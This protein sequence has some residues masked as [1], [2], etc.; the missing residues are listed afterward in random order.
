MKFT[1]HETKFHGN[2]SNVIPR[3]DLEQ[4]VANALGRASVVALLGP[5]Q[6]G[7]TTLARQFLSPDHPNY[8]DLEDP[9]SVARLSE[10]MTALESLEG[11]VVLDEIQHQPELFRILRVFVD[12]IESKT[13]FLVLGSAAP[14]L[15]HQATESLAGRIAYIQLSGFNLGEVGAD[16]LSR[17]WLRG[18]MPRSYLAA[19]ETDWFSWHTDF[20]RSYIERDLPQAGVTLAPPTILRFWT[21]LAHLHGQVFNGSDIARSI[22]ISE[23]TVRRWLDLFANLYLIHLLQPWHANV[24]KR[25]VKAP[26]LYLNDSGMLHALLGLRS[27]PALE[28]HPRCGASFEGLALREAIRVADADEVYFWGTHNRAELDL[29]LIRNGKRYGVEIKRADAPTVTPSM[30]IALSDLEL[31]RITVLYSGATSYPLSDKI[32]VMP[33]RQLAE[34]NAQD[35]LVG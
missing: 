30:R 32:S 15:L 23:S 16:C 7:K 31:Q 28:S 29:L 35:I 8:F 17:L 5:R 6:C 34:P 13:K 14:A 3:I 22:G 18:G 11:L 33:L 25:Q 19:K 2:N 4:R 20:M 10:P 21:M 27:L 26:K 1:F 24:A 9:R 12:R